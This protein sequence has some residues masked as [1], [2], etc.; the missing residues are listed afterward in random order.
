MK[1][2]IAI[3][4]GVLLTA[5]LLTGCSGNSS[6]VEVTTA[7]AK[8]GRDL[9]SMAWQ[10][11]VEALSTIDVM[12]GAGGKITEVTAA[13]GQH[14]N[15]GDVLFRIDNT[16][17][18][19]AL[20]QAKA[21]YDAAQAA[22]TS[23]KKASSQNTSVNPAQIDY[24]DAE[25]NFDRMQELYDGGV[26]SQSDYEAAKSRMDTARSRLQAAKNGQEGNYSAARAQVDSAKAALDIARKRFD[27]CDVTSPIT[28][29]VTGIHVD[30][31]QTVS[32]Q[33]AAATVI[34]DSGEKV[35]IQVA[36]TDID[37][38]K[39]GMPMT[40]SLQSAGQTLEG[41]ISAISA[42]CDPKTGMYTVKVRLNTAD[43]AHTAGLIANVRA[44][45]NEAVS[46]SVFI[47]ARCI[48][49]DGSQPF[50]YVIS[51]GSAVKKTVTTG[52]KKNA[53][54][55]VTEGLSP[56]DEVALQSSKPLSSGMKVRVLTVQ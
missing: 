17:A 47:P 45:E 35:E 18:A 32:A 51:D 56:G 15:T 46:G 36:D 44:A 13:E 50:V 43:A 7:A 41:T 16:D 39:D 34:D 53:Y 22:F 21:G 4:T 3:C 40:V 12:P 14:V 20:A 52:R 1:R 24:Q 8:S 54:M 9:S 25:N 30:P 49:N 10:G 26:I 6:Q 48:R 37:Q 23:A 31:G 2:F 29:M 27:D 38:L 28:G 55:E 42:V 5:G 19:L 33:T 11:T